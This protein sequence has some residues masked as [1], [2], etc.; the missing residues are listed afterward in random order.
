MKLTHTESEARAM[1]NA[2]WFA[3]GLIGGAA[4]ALLASPRSGRENRQVLRRRAREVADSVA[5]SVSQQGGA[6][7]EQQTQRVNEVLDRGKAEVQA[8]GSRVTEALD[9][10]K[11]AYR[12]AATNSQNG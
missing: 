8:F 12:A 11:S 5:D 7:V 3:L 6:F 2:T 1:S 9:K 10:G 4:V